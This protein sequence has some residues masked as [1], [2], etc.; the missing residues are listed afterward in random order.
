MCKELS[1]KKKELS[2]KYKWATVEAT[3]FTPWIPKGAEVTGQMGQY[4]SEV[5]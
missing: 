5:G 1:K 3:L 4:M 2:S